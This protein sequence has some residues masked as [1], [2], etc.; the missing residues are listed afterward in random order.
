[1]SKH[2]DDN[3]IQSRNRLS[4]PTERSPALT[5]DVELQA[6]LKTLRVA[7]MTPAAIS[8]PNKSQP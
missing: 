4:T 5:R 6:F 8:S 1:M 3:T 2:R 7:L